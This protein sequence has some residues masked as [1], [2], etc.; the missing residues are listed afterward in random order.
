[1]DKYG[2][3]SGMELPGYG[4]ASD[5]P[6]GVFLT[7]KLPILSVFYP[8]EESLTI[9]F[10]YKSSYNEPVKRKRWGGGTKWRNECM[11]SKCRRRLA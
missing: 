10:L 6:P 7:V 2:R 9:F 4:H 11:R 1:M 5:I 8:D 3:L